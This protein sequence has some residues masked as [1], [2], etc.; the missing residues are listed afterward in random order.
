MPSWVASVLITQTTSPSA[1]TA[2]GVAADGDRA[3]AP[4]GWPG[5][6]AARGPRSRRSTATRP[7]STASRGWPP[8]W[9]VATIFASDGFGGGASVVSVTTTATTAT[10]TAAA[11][12]S[13]VGDQRAGAAGAHTTAGA[14]AMRLAFRG[15][16]E[17]APQLGDVVAHPRVPLRRR[18]DDE[19]ARDALAQRRLGRVQL[20]GELVVGPLLDHVRGDQSALLGRQLGQ[21]RLGGV[22][23]EQPDH[24][25]VRLAD[26]A[27]LHLERAPHPLLDPA[28]ALVVGQAPRGDREQ[29]GRRR[30]AARLEAAARDERRGEGL[31]REVGGDLGVARA[32]GEVAEQRLDVAVVEH[33]ERLGVLRS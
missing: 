25:G 22:I 19:A 18:S 8:R 6:A 12:A 14:P 31:R 16:D 1:A 3:R 33:P 29:P 7:A 27:A 23:T 24:L 13:A 30:R 28:P 9:T 32:A 17:V 20:A 10:A 15:L 5:R 26:R 2:I 4:G 21:H 11:P